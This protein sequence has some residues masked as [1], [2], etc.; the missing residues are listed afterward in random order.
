MVMGLPCSVIVLMLCMQKRKNRQEGELPHPRI[1]FYTTT[2]A[3]QRAVLLEQFP[4]CTLSVQSV[5]KDGVHL[6]F[7][8]EFMQALEVGEV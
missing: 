5:D 6:N 1:W 7:D 2:K 3:E 8:E 4:E